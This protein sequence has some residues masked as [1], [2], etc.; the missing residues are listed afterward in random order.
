MKVSGVLVMLLDLWDMK[1]ILKFAPKSFRYLF[2][3][4]KK[5]RYLQAKV[6]GKGAT[7]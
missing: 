2:C 7:N 6:A 5:V 3:S 1:D 4:G